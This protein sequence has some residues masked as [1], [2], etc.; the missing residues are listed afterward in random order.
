ME[1]M[2]H[3]DSAVEPLRCAL[4]ACACSLLLFGAGC[5]GNFVN[6]DRPTPVCAKRNCE[7]GEII[8]DGC[9]AD[10]KCLSCSNDCGGKVAPRNGPASSPLPMR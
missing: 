10:G 9:S 3:V 7:T 8:D 1:A 4:R 6:P 5:P 2:R